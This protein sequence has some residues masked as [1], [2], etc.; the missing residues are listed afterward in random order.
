M[1]LLI[2]YET[3]L[4]CTEIRRNRAIVEKLLSSDFHEVG[5]SGRSFDFKSIIT[6]MPSEDNSRW[7]IHSQVYQCIV[8]SESVRLLIYRAAHCN[9]QGNYSNFCKRSSIWGLNKDQWQM[10]YHQATPCEA[11]EIG[12]NIS[13][14]QP[15]ICL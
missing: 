2:E 8:L 3:A 14:K 4:H 12:E 11:S 9:Q 5:K 6:M 13:A 10:K 1:E 15:V 7:K